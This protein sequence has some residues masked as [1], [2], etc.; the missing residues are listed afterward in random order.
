MAERE[1]LFSKD[2]P[3]IIAGPCAVESEEQM[4]SLALKLRKM[5][6]RVLRAMFWKPRSSP[7]SFQGVGRVLLPCIEEI[8]RKTGMHIVTEIVDGEQINEVGDVV[9]IYQVG[10]RNMQN[11]ELLKK[12]GMTSKPVILKRGLIATT[13]EWMNSA[14]YIGEDRV[15]LC[16]RGIR[17]GADS[18]RFTLDLNSLLVV[19]NDH[20]MPV[21]GDP[22]HSAGRSDMV[23]HLA[24]A[25]IACGADGVTIEVHENPE[26]ALCDSKQQITP[27]RFGVL[28]QDLRQL[29]T[30][31]SGTAMTEELVA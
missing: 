12:L 16:E 2:E 23:P 18:M 9:D 25:I 24:K 22:S 6:V 15:I 3:L 14:K 21:I 29:Y 10:A 26:I 31:T 7:E 30:L 17:T 19:K 11:Y 4:W 8:K 5:D 13:E 28:L 20:G 27:E 1:D